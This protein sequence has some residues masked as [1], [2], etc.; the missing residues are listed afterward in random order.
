M[1]GSKYPL[2]E[3]VHIVDE[4]EWVGKFGQDSK[5]NGMP[6]CPNCHKVF[7]EILRPYLYKALQKFGVSDLPMSWKHDN[8]ITVTEQ[9]LPIEED[10]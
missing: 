1:C 9:H 4:K 7:D 3:A 8:K 10:A 2:P 5:V 6:L